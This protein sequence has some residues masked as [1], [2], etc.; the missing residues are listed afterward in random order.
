MTVVNPPAVWGGE[1][2][3]T[4]LFVL[5]WAVKLVHSGSGQWSINLIP[6]LWFCGGLF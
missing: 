4:P 6:A 5:R 1:G 2:M 3:E